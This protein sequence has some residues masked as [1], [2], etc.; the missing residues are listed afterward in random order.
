MALDP[1]SAHQRNPGQPRARF[2]PPRYADSWG[3]LG[4]ATR[5]HESNRSSRCAR[6]AHLSPLHH[7]TGTT[8]LARS[9]TSTRH[10]PI[11]AAT[12]WTTSH[13]PYSFRTHLLPPL[14]HSPAQVEFEIDPPPPRTIAEKGESAAAGKPCR[15]SLSSHGVWLHSIWDPPQ[16]HAGWREARGSTPGTEI[17]RRRSRVAHLRGPEASHHHRRYGRLYQ[18]RDVHLYVFLEFTR[19]IGVLAEVERSPSM[20]TAPWCGATESVVGIEKK[21]PGLLIC[22]WTTLISAHI[23]LR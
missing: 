1:N 16:R 21:A 11:N 13:E 17:P 23:P 19:G 9:A 10:D 7:T 15:C 8:A 6:G 3:P 20:D 4:S 18:V 22:G 2:L 12:S 14:F 5:A